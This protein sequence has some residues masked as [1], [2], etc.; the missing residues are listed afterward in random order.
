[1]TLVIMHSYLQQQY[2]IVLNDDGDGEF[3]MQN[4]AKFAANITTS[5]ILRKAAANSV[6]LGCKIRTKVL[7]N[8][9]GTDEWF[10]KR[11]QIHVTILQIKA[12]HEYIF[13]MTLNRLT[14][15][16]TQ[17]SYFMSSIIIQSTCYNRFFVHFSSSCLCKLHVLLLICDMESK[18]Y[19]AEC[20]TLS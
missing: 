20:V 11:K 18:I 14:G 8:P 19:T 3:L 13:S 12:A 15:N 2:Y 9:D 1:M 16:H 5:S 10:I 6:T 17:T 4:H 7:W